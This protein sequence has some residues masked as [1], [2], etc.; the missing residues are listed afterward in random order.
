MTP[1]R[2]A[3]VYRTE[4][5]SAG[6]QIGWLVGLTGA[7][8]E[9]FRD[10]GRRL[11]D[12]LVTHLD[13]EE[14]E[15]AQASLRMAT[16]EAAEYGRKSADIGVSL[17]QAAEGFLRFRLPF[18]HQIAVVARRRGF[19]ARG[20]TALMED[21]ERLLDRLLIAAMNSHAVHNVNTQA[22]PDEPSEGLR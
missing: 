16:D 12:A 4:A 14:D 18:L 19:H 8:R 10:H 20:T 11:A 5:R 1:G 17:T 22:D 9:W 7:E 6:R 3:R 15:L 13:A 2:L 21:A